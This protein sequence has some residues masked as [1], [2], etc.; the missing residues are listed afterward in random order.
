MISS[1]PP[2]ISFSDNISHKAMFLTLSCRKGLIYYDEY[3]YHIIFDG[4]LKKAVIQDIILPCI[5]FACSQNM[6]MLTGVIVVLIHKT[7]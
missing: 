2:S 7:R 1:E 6:N 5:F 4:K 3:K